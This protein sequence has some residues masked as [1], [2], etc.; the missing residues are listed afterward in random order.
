MN[1]I[2]INSET[3][4]MNLKIILH[5]FKTQLQIIEIK[6][7]NVKNF[8]EYKIFM[9]ILLNNNNKKIDNNKINEIL[10]MRNIDFFELII[11]IM[12]DVYI[13]ID[14]NEM[15]QF[16]NKCM[17]NSENYNENE[18]DYLI[19]SNVSKSIYNFYQ[20]CQKQLKNY[21]INNIKKTDNNFSIYYN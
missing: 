4:I 9:C 15:L 19:I 18:N 16:L 8:V 13:C 17:E 14:N 11:K 5:Y 6:N 7:K 2:E 12:L 21:K 1:I 20:Y 3:L 10:K